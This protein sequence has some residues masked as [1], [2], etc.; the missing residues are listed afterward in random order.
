AQPLPR[1]PGT[2]IIGPSHCSLLFGYVGID[3]VLDQMRMKT[4][5]RGIE[6][7]IMV[8]GEPRCPLPCLED[9]EAIQ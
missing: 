6:F 2:C 1:P 9:T 3:A 8:V 7:N 5:K 4:I